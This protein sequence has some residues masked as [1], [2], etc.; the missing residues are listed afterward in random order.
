MF[1]ERVTEELLF[2]K[3]SA[4]IPVVWVVAYDTISAQ[5]AEEAGVDCILVG[6]TISSYVM[7]KKDSES[8]SFELMLEHASAVRR[9]APNVFLVGDLPQA[10]FKESPRE[11]IKKAKRYIDE[12]QVDCVKVECGIELVPIIKALAEAG[13]PVW[14]HTGMN[15]PSVRRLGDTEEGHERAEIESRLAETVYQFKKAGC[16]AVLVKPVSADLGKM[17]WEQSNDHFILTVGSEPFS[18]GMVINFYDLV[19]LTKQQPQGSR[20]YG[21]GYGYFLNLVKE[22]VSACIAGEYPSH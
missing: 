5:I 1:R 9:G 15:V 16:F 7:G 12:A 14:G 8:I 18:D 10:V 4:R 2:K 6:D 19:G 11:I 3:K 20:S 22:H 13:I 17:L 21:D